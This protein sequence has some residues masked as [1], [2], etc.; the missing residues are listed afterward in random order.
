MAWNDLP[1]ELPPNYHRARA[2]N[3]ALTRYAPQ[4][5]RGRWGGR[6]VA[7]SWLKSAAGKFD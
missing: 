7:S 6:V 4:P 5:D 1:P 2:A 3:V